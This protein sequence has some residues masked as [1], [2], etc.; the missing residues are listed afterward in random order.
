MQRE[1][2]AGYW[3]ARGMFDTTKNRKSQGGILPTKGHLEENH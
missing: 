2:Q 1:N 3:L